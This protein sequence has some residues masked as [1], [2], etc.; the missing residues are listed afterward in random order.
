MDQHQV[1]IKMLLVLFLLFVFVQS[2]TSTHQSTV[3]LVQYGTARKSSSTVT[4]L[5]FCTKIKLEPSDRLT[6]SKIK[7]HHILSITDQPHYVAIVSTQRHTV[8]SKTEQNFLVSLEKTAHCPFYS[9]SVWLYTS[10]N[11]LDYTK[12]CTFVRLGLETGSHGIN[13]TTQ[14]LPLPAFSTTSR[15]ATPAA[16]PRHTAPTPLTFHSL[17][18]QSAKNTNFIKRDT[19][20]NA[21]NSSTTAA[22]T[23][24]QF[25]IQHVQ[26]KHVRAIWLLFI[27]TNMKIEELASA[28]VETKE[29]YAMVVDKIG[30]EMPESK[31]LRCF[32]ILLQLFCIGTVLTLFFPPPSFDPINK[33]FD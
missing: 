28:G 8:I 14:P 19:S 27:E 2:T 29:L 18:I 20:N 4:H 1:M 6:C 30:N 32:V 26:P 12:R 5:T 7:L 17:P 9:A 24:T 23:A 25:G 31:F 21:T 15:T 3:H 10:R 22:T 13:P 33:F 11:T 16:V